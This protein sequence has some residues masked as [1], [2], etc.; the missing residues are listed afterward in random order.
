MGSFK[1]ELLKINLPG[2]PFLFS[3]GNASGIPVKVVEVQLIRTE[4]NNFI[5]IRLCVDMSSHKSSLWILD[6]E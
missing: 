4:S 5:Q 1:M 3:V 2:E 6:F